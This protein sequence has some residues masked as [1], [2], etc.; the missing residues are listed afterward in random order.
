M[1]VFI[2]GGLQ[3]SLLN[4]RKELIKDFVQAGWRVVGCA[5]ENNPNLIPELEKI[6]VKYHSV[7]MH[8]NG[9]NPLNDIIYKK[10][11]TKVILQEKPDLFLSYT[12][13]PVIFG[14]MAAKR[15]GCPSIAALITGLGYSFS[16]EKDLKQRIIYTVVKN[17]Y[18]KGLKNCNTIFFQNHD[19]KNLFSD[20][21]ILPKR[22]IVKVVSGS[23][24]DLDHYYKTPSVTDPVTFLYMARLIKA[25]GIK[26]YIL[27][28][29]HLK[30]R[31]PQSRFLI[32]GNNEKG[33]PDAIEPEL[34]KSNVDNGTVEYLG[35]TNDVRSV[36]GSSSV[37]VLPTYYREG[38]PRS[39][40]E[41]MAMAKPI[42]TTDSPGCRETVSLGKNGF[43]VQRKNLTELIQSMEYFLKDKKQIEAMGEE[44]YRIAVDRFDVK[45]VNKSILD[46]LNIS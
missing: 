1:K 28:A 12:V 14:S 2:L 3:S 17:L 4:F 23:G 8:R 37:F 38:I 21:G 45:K 40:L 46:A 7:P 16:D 9:M 6:Q 34:L 39:I 31:Y 19:D 10:E 11:L 35:S 15:A 30:E 36:L 29:S 42:I 24:V 33:N 27:A 18:K 41:A 43:L 5:P 32:L 25:K 13:K 26:E 22:A 20:L 44:S